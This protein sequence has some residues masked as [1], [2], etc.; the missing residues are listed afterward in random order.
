MSAI[1][2]IIR[3]AERQACKANSQLPGLDSRYHYSG[4]SIAGVL[5]VG[6]AKA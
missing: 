1:N 6:D 2:A 3:V 5:K 4:A